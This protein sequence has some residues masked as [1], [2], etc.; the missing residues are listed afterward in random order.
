MPTPAEAVA[1]H[2]FAVIPDLIAAATAAELAGA[3][4]RASAAAAGSLRRDEAV[5]G[6]RDL[7]RGVPEVRALAGSAAVI[8]WVE[9]ILGPG[10]FAVRGLWFDKTPAANWG[11]PWHQDLTIAVRE[12]ADAPGF[13]PWTSKGGIPH[14][15]P[16]VTVLAAMVTVRVHLDDCG[17]GRGPL[18]VI[19][20]SHRAGRLDAAAIRL[21]VAATP[22]VDCLVGRGGAVLMRPLILHSSR[23][24]TEPDRRRV[25]HLEYAAGPLPGGLAWFE[26]VAP[27]PPPPP[28]P[29]GRAIS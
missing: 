25:I 16:P 24:A 3:V 20:G 19:P 4:E 12:R 11:V 18:Q 14:V 13:G 17:P 26:A 21:A 7:L 6:M 9:A 29:A 8:D 2:G 27:P 28:P 15:R 1:D 5:Y 23:A 10:A 22:A